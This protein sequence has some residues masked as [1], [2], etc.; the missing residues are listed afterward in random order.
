MGHQVNGLEAQLTSILY[1]LLY[2]V[3]LLMIVCGYLVDVTPLMII[4][5]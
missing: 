2:I 3:S 4:V 5:E 1:K